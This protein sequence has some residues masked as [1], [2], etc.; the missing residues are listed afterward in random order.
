MQAIVLCKHTADNTGI[1]SLLYTLPFTTWIQGVCSG[2][3]TNASHMH[4]CLSHPFTH[5]IAALAPPCTFQFSK[6][7]DG[8]RRMATV[9]VVADTSLPLERALPASNAFPP[10]PLVLARPLC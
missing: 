4:A 6:Q 5:K 10:A 9:V 3:K 8:S 7:S 2:D 1:F